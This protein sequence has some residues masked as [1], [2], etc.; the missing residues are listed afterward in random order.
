MHRS[1]PTYLSGDPEGILTFDVPVFVREAGLRDTMARRLDVA[2][3]AERVVRG[4]YPRARVVLRLGLVDR[5][6][7]WLRRFLAPPNG[8]AGPLELPR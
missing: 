1:L 4:M 5:A 8:G 7:L 2:E 6:R 3:I